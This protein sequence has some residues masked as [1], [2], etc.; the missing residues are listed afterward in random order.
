MKGATHMG[1]VLGTK[2][3]GDLQMQ[4]DAL[5]PFLRQAAM[6]YEH[7]K[8]LVQGTGVNMFDEYGRMTPQALQQF[9]SGR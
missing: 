8:I 6:S 2:R 1:G 3:S 7:F 4:I 9:A 5:Q